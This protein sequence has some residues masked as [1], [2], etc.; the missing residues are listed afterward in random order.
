M[1]LAMIAALLLFPA[2]PA[3]AQ[4]AAFHPG[5][6]F[7][8]AGPIAD[9]ES[10]MPIPKGAVF[11]VSFDDTKQAQP[12]SVNDSFE[13]AARF[14][15]MHVAAG[16]PAADIHIGV[17]VH[18]K[19]VL[20]LL[21]PA[22]YAARTGGATN[23]SANLVAQLLA[24]NVD[25]YVCGQSAVAQNIAKADLLPGVKMALSAMN[26]YALLQ[27]QGYTLNPF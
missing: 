22:P 3:L 12:G 13:S 15:N 14:I 6:V 16:V 19:A 7:P 8:D 27:M 9:V 10:D 26:A 4:N 17:V 21:K 24:H 23:A 5:P 2:M 18:S 1:R 20:D 11:K 25:F